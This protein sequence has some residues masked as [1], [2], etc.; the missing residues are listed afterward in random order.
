MTKEE[1]VQELL[2]NTDLDTKL[3]ILLESGVEILTLKKFDRFIKIYLVNNFYVELI[4]KYEINR[5]TH[6]NLI[7]TQDLIEKYQDYIK[8][9]L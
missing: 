5:I 3:N 8:I 6:I 2:I 4:Y 9:V 7:D 1:L